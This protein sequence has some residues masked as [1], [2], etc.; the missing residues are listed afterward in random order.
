MADVADRTQL[1]KL[2]FHLG[3]YYS[4]IAAVLALKHNIVISVR[5]LQRI[6]R[7]HRLTR[8]YG[9]S[10]Y[11][12]LFTFLSKQLDGSGSSHGYRWMYQ[13]CVENGLV[14]KKEDVRLALL[15]LDAAGVKVRQSRRLSRRKYFSKGPNWIWHFDSYDKLKP[16][17][18]C[19]SGCVD[20]FS[21]KTIWLKVSHTSSD[22]RVIGAYFMDAVEE[23]GGCPR[24]CRADK[25][26]ENSSVRDLQRHMRRNDEDAFGKEMS[27]L[28]GRSTAN[29]RIESWWSFLRKECIDYWM[30][31]MHSL[32]D[33]GYFDGD[34]I[35]KQL[36]LF[37]FLGTLQVST[38]LS[39]EFQSTK[40]QSKV[41]VCRLNNFTIFPV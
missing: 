39:S 13:K 7:L 17:G 40:I 27:F 41:L 31:V 20:G 30:C 10:S 5:H 6:L 2:Y 4:D 21:R 8:R 1:I 36:L 37:C 35:D 15:V 29:Q 23:H 34:V 14:V 12:D 16:F 28:Y 11:A 24:I 18:L 33:D 26:T 22:P 25:G 38:Q 32:K 9:Y 19:I 3:L